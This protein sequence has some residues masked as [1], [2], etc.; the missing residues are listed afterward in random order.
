MEKF[1]FNNSLSV[2]EY[3]TAITEML[4][5]D[6]HI[7]QLSRNWWNLKADRLLAK[8]ETRSQ[9]NQTTH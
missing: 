9:N 6:K 5:H 1:E 7:A 2:E 3:Q 8:M 4:E